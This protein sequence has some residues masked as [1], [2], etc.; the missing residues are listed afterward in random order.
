MDDVLSMFYW[1]VR[2]YY[3]DTDSG[4]VVYY[5]NYLKFLERGRSEWLRSLGIE[6][7]VLREQSGLIFAVRS[8]SLDYRL[9]ARFNDQLYVSVRTKQQARASLVFTQQVLRLADDEV[10]QGVETTIEKQSA[11]VLCEGEVKVACLDAVSLKP[12]RIPDD[13]NVLLS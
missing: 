7:D 1:P 5:A 10:K 6:Q 9:P 12:R 11:T 2:V 13:I 3:E 4:G 8:I